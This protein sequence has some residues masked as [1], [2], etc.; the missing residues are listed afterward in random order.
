[1]DSHHY[2][3]SKALRPSVSQDVPSDVEPD[4]VTLATEI[5][6]TVR[7]LGTAARELESVP[8]QLAEP[9]SAPATVEGGNGRSGSGSSVLAGAPEC[10]RRPGRPSGRTYVFPASDRIRTTPVYTRK[11]SSLRQWRPRWSVAG[12]RCGRRASDVVRRPAPV[13]AAATGY[14]RKPYTIINLS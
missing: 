1:M 7:W 14:A 9:P 6:G 5:S 13:D 11:T 3:R 2:T 8:Q 12:R 4:D 10:P